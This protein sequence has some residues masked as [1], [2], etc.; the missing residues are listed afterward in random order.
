MIR[1]LKALGLALVAVFALSAMAASSA[2]AVDKVTTGVSPA[3]LTGVSELGQFK[4]TTPGEPNVRCTTSKYNVKV[5]SGASEI[6]IEPTYEGTLGVTPHAHHCN[7]S[8]A[9][10][11]EATVDLNGCDYDLKGETT[12]SDNGTDAT[13]SVTCPAGQEIT[14]TTNVGCTFHIPPQTPTSGGATTTNKSGK[15]EVKVTSTGIT[16]TTSGAFCALGGLPAEGNNADYTDTVLMS[17]TAW[18]SGTKHPFVEGAAT[19]VE[20]S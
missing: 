8:F 1:N 13:V 3:V 17:A 2:S 15:V 20:S 7:L 6:T 12:G 5:A 4:I 10:A 11:N 19:T 14:I 16:Y 18:T 9:G